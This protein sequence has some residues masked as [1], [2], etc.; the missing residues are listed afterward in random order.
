MSVTL[1]MLWDLAAALCIDG[2]SATGY[3]AQCGVP[4]TLQDSDGHRCGAG[5]H[6]RSRLSGGSYRPRSLTPRT[7]PAESRRRPRLAAPQN[8]ELGRDFLD[9][10][11]CDEVP[12]TGVEMSLDTA[13]TSACGTSPCN[14]TS[15]SLST[16]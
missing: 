14:S 11:W 1:Q 7:A 16:S 8:H 9:T 10:C 12:K 5:N 2:C 3:D 6:A 4:G 13:R 15:H